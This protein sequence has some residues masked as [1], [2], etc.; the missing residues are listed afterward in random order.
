LEIPHDIMDGKVDA[1]KVRYPKNYRV[2]GADGGPAEF[3][4]DPKIVQQVADL[5]ANAERPVALFGTQART[6]RAHDA[7]DRFSKHFNMPI[8]VN[9]SARGT[10]PRNHSHAFMPSRKTAFDN[11]D[12]SEEHTSELQS[13]GHLVCRLLLE[14]K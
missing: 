14:K 7:I 12:R 5:L 9:G 8:Y 1:S 10:L 11:A 4:G 3:I 6:C 13:R 2:R